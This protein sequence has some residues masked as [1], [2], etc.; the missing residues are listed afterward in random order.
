MAL[1]PHL[2]RTNRH[3]SWRFISLSAVVALAVAALPAA[4]AQAG[5]HPHTPSRSDLHDRTAYHDSRTDPASARIL[6]A[7]AVQLAVNPKAGVKALRKQLG[8]QGI[9]NL[10]PLTGTAR[11]VEKLNGFLTAPSRASAESIARAYVRSHP[12]VFGLGAAGVD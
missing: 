2:P 11:A 10:D 3:L 6:Q 9:V 8:M 12:D 1:T 4:T 7:R 5:P